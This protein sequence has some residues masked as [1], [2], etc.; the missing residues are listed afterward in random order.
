MT[1]SG[2]SLRRRNLDTLDVEAAEM[3]YSSAKHSMR[4][5]ELGGVEPFVEDDDADLSSSDWTATMMT[6]IS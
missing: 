4:I 3:T 6:E 1:V 2:V 5:V